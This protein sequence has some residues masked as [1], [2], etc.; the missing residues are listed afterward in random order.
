MNKPLSHLDQT[1]RA[2]ESISEYVG[3]AVAWL[4]LGLVLLI[5]YDVS[6]RYWFGGGSVA[7]QELEWHLFALLFLLAAG[8]T[9][10]YDEHVRLDIL[11]QR[12]SA[13]QRA[14]VNFI[15]GALVLLPLCALVIY[16][17][18]PFVYS[19]Y[20]YNERSPDP[21]GLPYRFLIRAAIPVGFFLLSI[22]ALADVLKN[23]LRLL[24][25]EP[26]DVV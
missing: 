16:N 7:A 4:S 25:H 8:Y 2:L 9:F 1:R 26:R 14:W 22:Q 20:S 15:G 17:S 6:M 12:F 24:G 5:S 11:Y 19:A 13:R 18:W 21:G 3:R 10:K 23:L